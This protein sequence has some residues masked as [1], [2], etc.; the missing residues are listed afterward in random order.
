MDGRSPGGYDG[1]MRPVDIQPIG[2]EVAVKWAD[3]SESFI[4]LEKLRRACPCAVCKGEV[5]IMGHL[6]IGPPAA[7][8]PTA[9]E[10]VTLTRVGGYAIQ[11]L[12][13]DGHA[14]GL[15]TFEN[16]KRLGEAP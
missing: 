14:S 16:L 12:W 10:M 9:F 6:H 1:L 5:D 11:P 13:G 7:L 2:N 15:F 8:S 3:G 4:S